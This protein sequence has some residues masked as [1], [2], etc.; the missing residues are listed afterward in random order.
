M[1]LSSWLANWLKR[2]RRRR[3]ANPPPR[4]LARLNVRRLEDRRVLSVTVTTNVAG[5]VTVSVAGN[6]TAQ[7][8]FDGTNLIVADSTDTVVYNA[9]LSPTADLTINGANDGFTQ[10][11]EFE[12]SV[13]I[14][15][16]SLTVS[17][18]I[19][20]ALI[21]VPIVVDNGA[22]SITV[23]DDVAFDA[24]GQVTNNVGGISIQAGAQADDTVTMASGAFLHATTGV[25]VSAGGDITLQQVQSGT[26]GVTVSGLNVTLE[27]NVTTTGAVSVTAQDNLTLTADADLNAGS[28]TILLR[29]NQDG[30]GGEDFVQHSGSQI[31]TSNNSST[32]VQVLVGGSGDAA[33]GEIFAGTTTGT[34]TI[35]AGGSIIDQLAGES[36]NVV[37]A[38]LALTA[39]TGIGVGD[40]LDTQ[41]ASVEAVTATGGVFLQN[42]GNLTIGGVTGSLAGVDVTSAGALAVTTAGSLVV[43]EG[44]SGPGDITLSATGSAGNLTINFNTGVVSTGGN[45][46]LSADQVAT[47]SEDVTT[48]GTGS[49]T[50]TGNADAGAKSI[51]VNNGAVVRVVNGHLTLD[52]DQ[53][54]ALAGT[55]NGV[56]LN[57]ATI[58][59]TGTGNI[60]IA[61]RAGS[62]GGVGVLIAS[63][64]I[65][66]STAAGLG[67]NQGTITITGTGGNGVNENDGVRLDGGGTLVTSIS[68]AISI[69]GTGGFLATGEFN[70]GVQISNGA[71]VSSTGTATILIVGVSGDGTATNGN[72]GVRFSGIG[73][74]VNSVHGNVTLDGTSIDVTGT[75]NNGVTLEHGA[76]ITISGSGHLTIIGTAATN[77][78]G[79][80]FG[81]KLGTGNVS[82]VLA[83][84]TNTFL[85]D[86]L[87]IAA[88]ATINAGTN[89]V[90]IAPRTAGVGISL[91]TAD[92]VGQLSLSDSELDQITC[93]RLIIG[94]ATAGAITFGADLDFTDTPFV[95]TVHLMSGAGINAVAGG[96]R[97]TDLAISANGNVVFTDATTNVSKLAVVIGPAGGSVTFVDA[98]GLMV[99]TVDGVA[100]I[101]TVGNVTLT[102]TTGAIAIGDGGGQDIAA[103][104]G[105]VQLNSTAGATQAAGSTITAAGLALTGSGTFTLTEHNEVATLAA[106]IN[107][108]LTYYDS[109]NFAVGTVNATVG[110]TTTGAGG[111]VSLTAGGTA[112]DPAAT[113]ILAA[114][115]TTTGTQLYNSH[116]VLGANAVL[117]SSGT[118]ASG[119]IT[120]AK[121]VND[122]GNPLT[123]SA[124]T[125]NTAGLTLFAAG[126]GNSSPLTSLTTDAAGTTN[127]AAGAVTTTGSQSYGDLVLTTNT[128]LTSTGGGNITLQVA[129]SGA[130]DL[131]INTSGVTTLPS[132]NLHSVTTDA[133]GTTVLNGNVTTTAFQ[134]Y[135]DN[136]TLTNNVTL[137]ST[138]G[139]AITI[140]GTINDDGA[141]GTPS[142]LVI[143]TAGATTLGGA[144]GNI[145]PINSFTTDAPGSLTLTSGQVTTTGG[146]TFNDLF[147]LVADSTF[148]STG[149][150]DIFFLNGLAGAFALVVNTTGI[151]TFSSTVHVASVQTNVGGVTRLGGNVT[152][153]GMQTFGDNVLLLDDVVLQ[154][155]GNAAITLGGMVDGGG[156]SLTITTAAT[157]T[158]GSN[159]SNL[160]SLT[161]DGGGITEI[162]ASITTSNAQTYLDA[163][164]LCSDAVLTSTAAGNIT[165]GSTVDDDGL[166]ATSSHLVINTA[167]TTNFQGAVG[168]VAIASL[169]TDGGGS[170]VL[171]GGAVLTTG[172]Q[173]YGDAVV[174]ASNAV[175]T[176]TGGGAITFS[177]T[178][179]ADD[180]AVHNRTLTVTTV[181]GSVTFGG[182]VGSGPNGALADLD[183]TAAAIQLNG[184]MV[185]VDDQGGNTVTFAGAVLLGSNVQLDTNG[186]ADNHLSILGT[187]NADDATAHNRTLTIDAGAG[188]VTFGG[189]IGTH[190]N[191]ALADLDVTAAV[192]QFN[193]GM[194]RVDDQGGNTVTLNGAVVLGT[195]VTIDTDGAADNH[196][197]VGGTVDGAHLLSIVAGSG[198]VTFAGAVGQ[199]TPLSGLTINS[200]DDVQFQGT[201]ATTGNLSVISRTVLAQQALT[202]GG[203]VQLTTIDGTTLTAAADIFAGTGIT[204]HG[205][206]QTAA[207]LTTN[208]GAILLNGAVTLTGNVQI[209]SDAAE[210]GG[211]AI[212]LTGTVDLSTFG[213][214][215]DAGVNGDIHFQQTVTGTGDLTVQQGRQQSYEALNV[216]NLTILDATTS[217]TLNGVVVALGNVLLCSQGTIA[218]EQSLTAG[219]TIDFCAPGGLVLCGDI[220]AAGS[221]T[222]QHAVVLC[223]T[224]LVSSTGGGDIVFQSTVDSTAHQAYGLTVNTTG[225][226]D[227]QA[228]VGAGANQALGSLT[229]NAGGTTRLAASVTTTGEQQYG[230]AVS[231]MGHVV[232]TGADT[233]ASGEAIEFSGT[234]SG[235]GF[236][237]TVAGGVAFAQAVSGVADFLADRLD[238]EST[239]SAASVHVT[240]TSEL[241]GDVTT[242]STQQYDSSVLLTA[243]VVATSTGGAD[244]TFGGT[245]DGVFSLVVN[246]SG[247]T[248]FGGVVGGLTPLASLQTD[249]AGAT[250]ISTSAVNA[251]VIQ[252]HDAV[253]VT[254]STTVTGSTSVAFGGAVAGQAGTESLIVVSSG[255]ATF[256]GA[257]GHLANL[258]VN[259]DGQTTLNGTVTISGVFQ[260]NAAGVTRINTAAISAG[261]VNLLDAVEI[262]QNLTITAGAITFGGTL[263]EAA[264]NTG[265]NLTLTIT[266]PAVGDILFL[267]AVGATRAID[268]L[269]ITAANDVTFAATVETSG[270]LVQHSGTGTTTF[271]GTSGGG[272][273]GQLHIVTD[274]VTFNAADVVTV[275][276]VTIQAQNAI[277]FHALAGLN[278]GAS[279]IHLSANL[280]GVGSEGFTQASGTVIQTTSEASDA[281]RIVV[282]GTGNVAVADVRA[283]TITGVVALTAGGAILDNSLGEAANVTA[284]AAAL[285]AETG[286]GASDDLDTAVAQAAF[287]NSA[288]GLVQLTDVD[289]LTLTAVDGL[290][291]SLAVAGGTITA[292]HALT[293]AMT[294]Q[295][296][297]DF[298]CVAANDAA[299][300]GNNIVIAADVTHLTGNG[301][302]TF[303][304]GDDILHTAGVISNTGGTVHEVCFLAD[305]EGIAGTDGD[306]GGITQTG[307]SL[308]AGQ[309]LFQAYESVSYQQPTNDVDVVAASLAGVGS[310]FA[311]RDADS[312]TVGTVK[313]TAGISTH[314]GHVTLITGDALTIGSGA[315]EDI[316]ASGATVLIDVALNGASEQAGS[317]IQ[318]E[319]L[320]LQG[321]GP[322]L[323]TQANDV[324]TLAANVTGPIAYSDAD[325]V[326]VGTVGLTA[327]VN[328]HGQDVTLVT[329]GLLTIGTGAGEDVTA[330]GATVTL[331]SG[332]GVT[333]QGGSSIT[334]QDLLLLG[335]GDFHLA[336]QNDV[337]RLAANIDGNLVYTDADALT[338][339]TVGAVSG[340][341]TSND[342]V[343]LTTGGDLQVSGDVSLG[344]ADL[345]LQVTGAVTQ[346]AGH[347]VSARGLQVVGSGSVAL[348]D[349]GNDVDV[350][351]ADFAG[352]LSYSDAD[353]VTVGTVGLTA[354]VNSHGQDVTL[355]TGGLLTIG[356]GAGEDVT[357]TGAT[358]TL[359]SGSGVTEQGGSTITADELLL[360]GSGQFQLD[361]ANDV[362]VLAAEITG[363]LSY[364]DANDLTIGAVGGVDGIRTGIP[365]DGGDVTITALGSLT[366]NA[367]IST[368]G[369]AG[370]VVTVG[371]GT[372]NAAL[373]AGAGDITLNS[374]DDDLVINADQSSTTTLLY[375]ARCDVIINATV[376]TTAAGADVVVIGDSDHN[377]TGGVWVTASGQIVSAGGIH[378]SGSDVCATAGDV[379]SVRIDDD[380]IHTQLQSTGDI[381]LSSLAAAPASADILIG[382]SVHSSTG[383][384]AVDA[385][386]TI[387]AQSTVVADAGS[388][389]LLDPV[390]LTG[391]LQVTAGAD[392]TFA[393]TVND[394]GLPGTPSALTVTS[395]GITTFA[396]SVGHAAP[397]TSL[398]ANGGG[399][400]QV[401][402]NVTTTGA[403]AYGDAVVL[404][405]D[406]ALTST[407]GGNITF[408]ST[409]DSDAVAPRALSVNTAGTTGFQG[410]VGQSRA[411][412]SV[413]TDAGGVTL[414]GGGLVRTTGAQSYG[415]AVTLT[416]QTVLLTTAGAATGADIVVAGPLHTNGFNLTLAAGTAGDIDLQ[417]VVSGGGTLTVASGDVIEFA[418]VTVDDLLVLSAT[419]SVTLHGAVAVANNMTV[420]SSGQIVQ[421]QVVT[422]G[423]NAV[424]AAGTS[425]SVQAPLL[426]GM[427]IDFSAGTSVSVTGS[428]TATTGGIDV[429]AGTTI[430]IDGPL[431]AGTDVNLTAV[432]GVFVNGTLHAGDE[433]SVT[434]T[435]GAI[436]IAN[437]VTA[438]TNV[439]LT[440]AGNL[441]VGAAVTAALGGITA[442]AGDDFSVT[443]SLLAAGDVLVAAGND[444]AVNGMVVAGDNATLTAAGGTLLVGGD[445]LAGGDV[446]L[447]AGLSISVAGTVT[448]TTGQLSATAGTSIVVAGAV[449]AAGDAVLAAQTDV[450]ISGTVISGQAV[451]L[452][453][454]LGAIHVVGA[455]TAGQ[456]VHLTSGTA[457]TISGDVTATGGSIHAV[458]GTSFTALGALTAGEDVLVQSGTS[459]TLNGTVLAAEDIH[460]QAGTT[461]SADGPLTAGNAV[462]LAA[463]GGITLSVT[464]DIQAG[465][466]GITVNGPLSTA[467][468]FL[469]ANGA[470]AVNGSVTLLAAVVWDSDALELGGAPITVNGTISL[471]TFSLTIDAG[472]SGD[473]H[474]QGAVSGTGV[475]TVQEGDEQTYA[476]LTVGALTILDATTSVT[477]TGPVN[478]LGD[479][480]ICSQGTTEIQQA[481]TAGGMIDLCATSGLWLFGDITAGSDITFQN[482][483]ILGDSIVVTSTAGGQVTFASTVDSAAHQA[484][485]LTVNTSGHT[486]FQGAVGGGTHQALGYVVTDAGG[487]TI[488]A[489]GVVR[490]TGTQFYGDHLV[491]LG[492]TSLDTTAGSPAGGDL[493]VAGT[494]QTAGFHLSLN[495]GTAGDIDVQGSVTGGGALTV[496][497]GDHVE[498]GS[499][500]VDTLL[501]QS[502]TSSVTFH[503]VVVV[504]NNATVHSSGSIVQEQSIVA[505]GNVVYVAGTSV[506]AEGS[507]TA[508]QIALSAAT[509]DITVGGHLAANQGISLSAG[510]DLTVNGSASTLLGSISFL[511]GSD[512]SITGE[513]TAPTVQLTTLAGDVQLG[514]TVT[515]LDSVLV[516]AGGSVQLAADV[517]ATSGPVS[518]NAAGGSLWMTEGATVSAL[519]DI[520]LSA[521]QNIV[522]SQVVTPGTVTLTTAVGAVLDGGDIGGAD[523]VAQAL[524]LNTAGG[525]GV[526][527]ALETS[528]HNLAGVNATSGDIAIANDVDG[529]LTLGVAGSVVGL[530]N[531]GGGIWVVNNGAITVQ[532]PVSAVG[533]GTIS[534]EA[535]A[536][537]G[538]DDH[539][540]VNAPISATGGNGSVLLYAG[541]DLV[542]NDSGSAPEVR[543]EQGGVIVGSA[544]R[545]VILGNNVLLQ[546]GSGQVTTLPPYVSSVSASQISAGGQTTITLTFSQPLEVGYVI[547]IRSA[548][549]APLYHTVTAAEAGQ[550]TIQ[551]AYTAAPDA[552]NA[553]E[554]VTIQ[555]VIHTPASIRLFEAGVEITETAETTASNPG[556]GVQV[557]V[558]FDTAPPV[559]PIAIPAPLVFELGLIAPTDP[560]AQT[561]SLI[562]LPARQDDLLTDERAVIL[563]VLA[564]D[565]SVLQRVTL[566]EDVLDDLDGVVKQLP[567]GRYRFLLREP[568]ESRL[569]LLQDVEVRQGRI[570]SDADDARD[571]PPGMKP[572]LRGTEPPRTP[573]EAPADALQPAN[574]PSVLSART[575]ARSGETGADTYDGEK[576]TDSTTGETLGD[577]NPGELGD[578]D[579]GETVADVNSGETV[580][581]SEAIRMGWSGWRARRAWVS[582]VERES[583]PAFDFFQTEQ[584]E[585]GDSGSLLPL[586][587]LTGAC[588]A[589]G[590][591]ARFGRGARLRRKHQWC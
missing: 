424:Y 239:L 537:G 538:D 131:V 199:L 249:A 213:L 546:S 224:I 478:A 327:G 515:A 530:T 73:A 451:Q 426:A 17:S 166:A 560:L 501:V 61:G 422:V 162:C 492:N 282:G 206:L 41:V 197:F 325:D 449:T 283:G 6:D 337:D 170:T 116:V 310:S 468:D 363:S 404:C 345:T 579:P 268:S 453:A 160:S 31:Q 317:T 251:D 218:V 43:S 357:A 264:L 266:N 521:W 186:A 503:G 190:A 402:G 398:T 383:N 284:A 576:V 193:G 150:G 8:S 216:G 46:K 469:T 27:A 460:V 65:V 430:S 399:T 415:D 273:G 203:N 101:S 66:R 255:A 558:P 59:T 106:N 410:A 161:T 177:G 163:V 89:T 117:A 316:S 76:S 392:V 223:N 119:N 435:A 465:G 455:I 526:G 334:A 214:T 45:I 495:A 454:A 535:A 301:S 99:G 24:D 128:T 212:T 531:S 351:A 44:V 420:N 112:P 368:Q 263:D 253:T 204:M 364:V 227:F 578:L 583:T 344:A 157:T 442:L 215:V 411:L 406:L 387:R 74:A 494:V 279:T 510:D 543:V 348:T 482:A 419:T 323:L 562:Y 246:T 385:A 350:L 423:Q 461:L 319:A 257:V 259:A 456:Q 295:A 440:A 230:D 408:H 388:I 86:S 328:S 318:A 394:D 343:L 63:A 479:I 330:T 305:A 457:T 354:G 349:A 2:R 237:L 441:S 409:V 342:H 16:D 377:G 102:A 362:G 431:T 48:T 261:T 561:S 67:A 324:N 527:N 306:R 574:A 7:I 360:K 254:Q 488:L 138:G 352:A 169:T 75:D 207:D 167:G 400:T 586:L 554:E 366:V 21:S 427:E 184:G 124:L 477:L 120:F 297:G 391:N 487:V 94:S 196:L 32:A 40:D 568:G 439:L 236:D 278:A 333:E 513:L 272:I 498:F 288:S 397:L 274:A 446:A 123:S 81:I 550:A 459:A 542:I 418:A 416:A 256:D 173:S 121:D 152:T 195:D 126:V 240:G 405:A 359:H 356:T 228:A 485:G 133:G 428:L 565:G 525:A 191:G 589:T 472:T 53:G 529:P 570:S 311:F 463:P 154:S 429:Q 532:G 108:S 540:V 47:I 549:A 355:V 115:V 188:T 14:P 304:A 149:G 476:A 396:G 517:T 70:D 276:A 146:Q 182:A 483:V 491:L 471:S 490:T 3:T 57:N 64:S 143:N 18:S 29:A 414:I 302:L 151:T 296:G 179:N 11:V 28:A 486:T 148:T 252:F 534:L 519:G 58:E 365:A 234:V 425:I 134:T 15:V 238:S 100:G 464:A 582:S 514:G 269:T 181:G 19:E 401:C 208:N 499:L 340:I 403:Q 244:I 309:V 140:S 591:A 291:A 71:V 447:Q 289:D 104:T 375:A 225:L 260:T 523:V 262:A 127:L 25:T 153:S 547:E 584:P 326:T 484:H 220:T 331:H 458:A 36:A 575:D 496:V 552:E 303:Q 480:F 293:I 373:I 516:Q 113:I 321:T 353:D 585:N 500:T 384:I 475:L 136:L 229:T 544:G 185:R 97:A 569:R 432:N 109:N 33:V 285:R 541:T 287:S 180:A 336:Q 581:P 171:A 88:T 572:K 467:A 176:S 84:A 369:G 250:R 23:A 564:P 72:T 320:L 95:Q 103:G 233:D 56:F 209:D 286:I 314:A 577:V 559:T 545:E 381:T 77:N 346:T 267:N 509:G 158:L 522:L 571:R 9:A 367:S 452:T 312:L 573:D 187:V 450:S 242:S 437:A 50:V 142:N 481:L 155:T 524:V 172:L 489:G 219:G 474:L 165:F 347:T 379:D 563:E 580:A 85:A 192:I 539:L 270:S 438:G 129:V 243:N 68:G 504:S 202:V 20:N 434:A 371:G 147:T 473:V 226:T 443:G 298:D 567:D 271:H 281:V 37:A 205:S 590:V 448:A 533:G 90:V 168:T 60:V 139:G 245:V 62:G 194:V 308:L 159:L 372:I 69:T 145:S 378:L 413:S 518:L 144:V 98:S 111:H 506:I 313:S 52:A 300:A 338:I 445:L 358:V 54:V 462:V 470:I 42:T 30:S 114:N 107:G 164:V 22:V 141:S 210:T 235:N 79:G 217:I 137:T 280:D 183:V 339:G 566:P 444:A 174:I 335:T 211:A 55:F 507:L 511:A 502:A 35:S 553:A 290:T 26:G 412:S 232:L 421:E 258:T 380:G 4:P 376:A 329:G 80:G 49:I 493:F 277:T 5:D 382:G 548:G 374:G 322:F 222:F 433:I 520:T 1:L 10:N 436:D 132:A 299:V 135:H 265:S 466:G 189:T 247:W 201:V 390:V 82:L 292:G 275:G 200:A 156:K 389:D 551:I 110:I 555:I 512:M 83:G 528:V 38:N 178:V 557:F 231:L 370:G 51:V 497:H 395:P 386:D 12:G 39:G 91:G 505:G 87:F 588:V 407:T 536:N 294:T 118:G 130:F 307:G 13:P 341:T 175:L 248:T 92:L 587:P 556:L 78:P 96:I 361:E 417:Q 122:D 332:S 105:N 221:I 508:D 241:G 34:V 315:G 93:G 393:D 198:D 125:V